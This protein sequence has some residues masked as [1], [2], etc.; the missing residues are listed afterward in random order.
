MDSLPALP[1]RVEVRIGADGAVAVNGF[2]DVDALEALLGDDLAATH[3]TPAARR[4]R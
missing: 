4:R 1:N 3:P 2:A